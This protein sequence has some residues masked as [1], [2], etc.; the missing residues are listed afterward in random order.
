MRLAFKDYCH[1][2]GRVAIVAFACCATGWFTDYY[3]AYV[4]INA[5]SLTSVRQKPYH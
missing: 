2:A 4:F 3:V 1:V 5:I